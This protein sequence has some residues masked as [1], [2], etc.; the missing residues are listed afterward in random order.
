M[1]WRRVE[2]GEWELYRRADGEVLGTISEPPDMPGEY[3]ARSETSGDR[4]FF[5]T[6][7]SAKRFVE[8][9]ER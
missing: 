1:P 8:E 6:L 9:F 2:K 3:F 4:D 5:S 7:R